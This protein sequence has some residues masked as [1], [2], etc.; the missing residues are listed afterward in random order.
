LVKRLKQ[1]GH[2][3][4]QR[5]PADERQVQVS[6]TDKGRA[7]RAETKTLAEALYGKSRM[8]VA[9]VADLNVRVTAL[10]DAFKAAEPVASRVGPT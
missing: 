1:A 10:R 5:N 3:L 8:S 9:E 6:L 7:L 2:V 4:R